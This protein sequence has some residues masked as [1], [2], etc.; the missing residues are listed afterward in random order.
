MLQPCAVSRK[1][2]NPRIKRVCPMPDQ[3]SLLF[4]QKQALRQEMLARRK[5]L[6]ASE[7]E[8]ISQQAQ[9]HVLALPE[10]HG[11]SKILL[12]YPVNNELDT[13]FLI[14]SALEQKKEV[15]LPRC[16]AG[17]KGKME[18]AYCPDFSCLVPGQF[19]IME[20]NPETCPALELAVELPLELAPEKTLKENYGR[21]SAKAPAQTPAQTPGQLPQQIPQQIS[22]QAS[23]QVSEQVSVQ[24][25]GQSHVPSS[26]FAVA[27]SSKLFFEGNIISP[28]LA[29]LPGLAFCVC[30]LRLGYG[31]GYYDRFLNENKFNNFFLLGF[32]AS[33]QVL[34]K[35]PA[36]KWD[37][38]LD[39]IC[40]EN[41]IVRC[42][43][44]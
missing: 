4:K 6:S 30:G 9:K 12:Y 13:T 29:I 32:G 42:F 37:Y 41:G 24:P 28:H 18:L 26:D 1:K 3:N 11:A 40:T 25:S 31:G 21:E 27:A 14:Q 20:P 19:G 2:H 15:L 34:K 7:L 44:Q 10:W 36:G 43:K 23:R 5:A 8:A 17:Q 38:P 35:L 22:G 16:I 33:F 39:A